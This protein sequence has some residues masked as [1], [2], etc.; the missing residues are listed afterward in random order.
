MYKDVLRSIDG[1]AIYPIMSLIIFVLFF[2]LLLIYVIKV[3]NKFINDMK[4]MPF[5]D[6]KGSNN[7]SNST[8][9]E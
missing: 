6:N 7:T 2:S 4:N 3:D 8:N 9:H 5:K 1:I